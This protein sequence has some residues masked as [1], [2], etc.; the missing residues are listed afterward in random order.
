[1]ERLGETPERMA[2]VYRRSSAKVKLPWLSDLDPEQ[3]TAFREYG[4]I[5]MRDVLAALDA[6]T[7][8]DR[9]GHLAG[10]S[11][12][13]A[14]YGVG[15]AEGG[16]GAGATV[17]TFLRFR[18]TFI[19]ELFGLAARRGLETVATTGLIGRAEDALDQLLVATIHG[20]EAS[21]TAGAAARQGRT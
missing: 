15:A 6:A 1:M 10:A 5:I 20:W 4:Q 7:E 21:M 18:R 2:R 12:A 3:R 11:A 17:E 16:L 14:K 8:S 9:A 13:C 19:A